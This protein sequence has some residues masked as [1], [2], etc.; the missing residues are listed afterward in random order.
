MNKNTINSNDA[1]ELLEDRV[2][3]KLYTAEQHLRNLRDLEQK[4]E[5]ILSF[6]GRVK[7]EMEIECFLSQ[8][9]GARDAI[10]VQINEKFGLKLKKEKITLHNVK[11]ILNALDKTNLLQY[12]N[13][14]TPNKDTWFWSL[15]KLRNQSMHTELIN[16]QVKHGPDEHGPKVYFVIDQ[17][18]RFDII[19]YL[20]N[21][22]QKMKDIIDDINRQ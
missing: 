16:I 4:N 6:P 10:L 18:K 13:M 15:N 21:G 1:Q 8:L 19:P 22:L 7:W 3:F 12:L 9:I 14:L 2:K 20:E 5:T 17:Q 11:M